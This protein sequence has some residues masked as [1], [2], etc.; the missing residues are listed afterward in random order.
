[1]KTTQHK[2]NIPRITPIEERSPEEVV[3]MLSEELM[4]WSGDFIEHNALTKDQKEALAAEKRRRASL[5]ESYRNQ[6]AEA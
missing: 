3:E 1:M 2:C 5:P 6:P 4:I